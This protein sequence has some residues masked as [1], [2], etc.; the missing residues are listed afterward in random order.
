MNCILKA[1][2]TD[3]MSIKMNN[4]KLEPNTKFDLKPTFSRQIRKMTDNDK[5]L[6]SALK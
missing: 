1:I 2:R 6:L 4:I 3:E 5:V